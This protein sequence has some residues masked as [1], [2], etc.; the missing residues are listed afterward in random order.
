MTVW[1]FFLSA[2]VMSFSPGLSH[3]QVPGLFDFLSPGTFWSRDLQGLQVLSCFVPGPS[4]DFLG[5]PGTSI[6]IPLQFLEV[7]ITHLTFMILSIF[8]SDFCQN[9]II[10]FNHMN[11]TTL[12][13]ENEELCVKALLSKIY[14]QFQYKTNITFRR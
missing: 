3:F 9:W 1:I 12:L 2:V 10:F 8:S 5:R 4:R 7:V 13:V 6:S 14:W 11:T